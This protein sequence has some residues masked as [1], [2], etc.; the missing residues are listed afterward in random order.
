MD[1]IILNI[2]KEFSKSPGARFRTQGENSAE[3]FFEVHLLPVF[4]KALQENKKLLV[5]MDG[6]YGYM[7][8]FIDEAFGRL[9]QKFDRS[10]IYRILDVKCDEEPT[11]A[12][13]IVAS[14][15]EWGKGK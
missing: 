7:I 3:E 11:L 9:A 15:N 8:G 12:D 10:V 2:A 13:E 1:K 5:D 6:G 14:T 4:T